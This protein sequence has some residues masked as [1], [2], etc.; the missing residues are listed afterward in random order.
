MEPWRRPGDEELYTETDYRIPRKP[1]KKYARGDGARSANTRMSPDAPTK[2]PEERKLYGDTNDDDY[3]GDP[4]ELQQYERS[5]RKGS[6]IST[7]TDAHGKKSIPG[8]LLEL[9][10]NGSGAMKK[11]NINREERLS[12]PVLGDDAEEAPRG[13]EAREISLQ[14]SLPIPQVLRGRAHVPGLSVSR[15]LKVGARNTKKVKRNRRRKSSE[16]E[17]LSEV[18]DSDNDDSEGSGIKS[19]YN[20]SAVIPEQAKEP[21]VDRMQ[22]M[23]R[24]NNNNNDVVREVRKIRKRKS[25]KSIFD[26]K[27]EERRVRNL[28]A[29]TA[30]YW[31]EQLHMDAE[32]KKERSRFSFRI[33]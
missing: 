12:G 27:E 14:Q 7:L 4:R 1:R 16:T 9:K 18:E 23:E 8:A 24:D 32:R 29:F 21:H 3:N 2:K 31:D 5:P 25:R 6:G 11:A 17:A 19:I 28:H 30:E 22:L 15:H 33:E 13:T 10:R 20:T 26:T